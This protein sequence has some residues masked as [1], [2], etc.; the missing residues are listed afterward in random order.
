[1]AKRKKNNNK[2]RWT[3]KA[4]SAVDSAVGILSPSRAFRRS[5]FRAAYEVLDQHRTRP[6]P[7][8]Y[9]PGTADSL[10]SAA[11]LTD[12]AEYSRAYMR[13]NPV[14][15]GALLTALDKTFG[16]EVR[17][18]ARTSDE[19]WN[20]RA[21]DRWTEHM[22]NQPIDSS[23]RFNINIANGISYLSYLGDGDY[24]Q[25]FHND[26]IQLV[27]REQC[28]LPFGL[29]AARH[30]KVVNGIA[31]G[32]ETGKLIGYYIGTP[33]KSGFYIQPDSFR[34]YKADKVHHIF[35][36]K[37]SSQSRG[38]PALTSAF[39]NIQYLEHYVEA[40]LVAACV[41][42]CFTMAVTY[43]D[44]AKAPPP[45][46]TGAAPTGENIHRS[47]HE[48][49]EEGK[50]LYFEPGEDVTGVGMERPGSQFETF[51]RRITAGHG[52]PLGLP[53]MLVAGDFSGA[54]FMNSRMAMQHAQDR[55]RREQQWVIKPLIRK[56]W[57][58]H[59]S[60]MVR[61]GELEERPD[62]FRCEVQPKRWAYVDP[63]KEAKA[64]EQQLKNGTINRTIID[65]RQGLDY[66]DVSKKLAEEQAGR[67]ES[68]LAAD[69]KKLGKKMEDISRAV[70]S[71]VPIAVA[72][73]R[74]A[75]GLTEKPPGGELL[76]FND[77]DVLQY[78]IE[79]GILTINEIRE[80]LGLE[81]VPWGDV[82]ARKAGV[83]PV[84]T[85]GEGSEEESES[86]EE[87]DNEQDQQ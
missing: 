53:L 11:T 39:K 18:Q 47:K 25:I 34:K 33:D 13:N 31:Y 36:P 55:W 73:A 72:E 3:A 71:G 60:R 12:L 68:G 46:T 77:Q 37:R 44:P 4:A 85:D 52:L 28:G 9:V 15:E 45:F 32:K 61:M 7:T 23:G 66:G 58:W 54:T 40:E 49:I 76:R 38:T 14:Y 78:H 75:L 51:V 82:A 83:S 74:T 59:I 10:L 81:S 64:D 21:E 16:E 30:Y 79:S 17:I 70:R 65:A 42:A 57:R 22:V 62:M 26:S 43:K 80:V 48:G 19:A 56:Q 63:Y 84:N 27:E 35:N 6:R 50:I 67:K 87:N 1:M 20:A 2:K 86:D 8:T 5:Q 24:F 29:P 41:N 69:D